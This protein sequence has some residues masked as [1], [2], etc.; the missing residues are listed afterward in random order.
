M[1]L[2]LNNALNTWSGECQVGNLLSGTRIGTSFII[3]IA[4][5]IRT[6]VKINSEA[7]GS[8]SSRLRQLGAFFLSLALKP[9]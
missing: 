4:S 7:A 6:N 2:Q 8:K 3:Q 5:Y 9:P 1:R